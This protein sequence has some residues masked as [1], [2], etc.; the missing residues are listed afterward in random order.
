MIKGQFIDVKSGRGNASSGTPSQPLRRGSPMSP[1]PL[2]S[3]AE[4]LSGCGLPTT[5]FPARDLRNLAVFCFILTASFTLPLYALA[6]Y[7]LH[8]DLYSHILLVPFISLYLI[9]LKRPDLK[10]EPFGD[11]TI[12]FFP[13]AA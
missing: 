4:G 9:W 11:R 2:G 13:L 10:L 5:L 6:S 3:T 12:V 1:S 8:S 7:A